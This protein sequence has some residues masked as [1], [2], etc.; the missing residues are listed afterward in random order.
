MFRP[1]SAR[2]ISYRPLLA[3]WR[4][5][6]ATIAVALA[7][8]PFA[9]SAA[10]T[11]SSFQAQAQGTQ[12]KLTWTTASEINNAGFNLLRSTSAG[13]TYTKINGSLIPTNCMGCLAGASYSHND[14]GVSTGQTYYY[15]LQ[16]VS[17]TG[18]LEDFGPQSATL[19][20]PATATATPTA[21]KVNTLVPT[22]TK[23]FTPVP[24]PTNAPTATRTPT[25]QLQPTAVNAATPQPTRVARVV[26][27]PEP[28]E[29]VASVLQPPVPE[30]DSSPQAV[31]VETPESEANPDSISA[32]EEPPPQD[33]AFTAQAPTS[34]TGLLRPLF[35]LGIYGLSGMLALGGFFLSI[36]AIYFLLYPTRR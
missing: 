12:I 6:L 14:S 28:T 19:G 29:P 30:S 32:G 13:G 20:S 5:T 36:A 31:P 23:T 2:P 27:T 10:V 3:H 1:T 8:I 4:L 15:K 16:S 17:T 21:T 7:L 11:V 33:D 25:V 9:T 24:S 18:Q 35:A 26:A 22:P 34:S